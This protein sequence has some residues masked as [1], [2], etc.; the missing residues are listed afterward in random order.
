MQRL[1]KLVQPVQQLILD[2]S[3]KTRVFKSRFRAWNLVC[4][5]L[6]PRTL[7]IFQF[8]FERLFFS[9]LEKVSEE[10]HKNFRRDNFVLLFCIQCLLEGM[11]S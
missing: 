4:S 10:S 8:C 9:F 2:N 1:Q 7:Q 6:E 3:W 11:R 5:H